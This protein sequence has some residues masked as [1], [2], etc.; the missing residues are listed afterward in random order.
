M[1]A[2]EHLY[3]ADPTPMD[4]DSAATKRDM[5]KAAEDNHILS[6]AEMSGLKWWLDDWFSEWKG[7]ASIKNDTHF[8]TKSQSQ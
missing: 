7:L 5:H 1:K 6:P 4:Q 8:L 3:L 2:K